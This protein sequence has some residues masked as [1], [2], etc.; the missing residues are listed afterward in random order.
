MCGANKM[1]KIAIYGGSFNPIT[2]GHIAVIKAIEPYVDEIWII[3]VNKHPWNK[4]LI[5]MKHRIKMIELGLNNIIN[6]NFKYTTIKC[7]KELNK[8]DLSSHKRVLILDV[9][10]LKGV[11]QT[12]AKFMEW[13]RKKCQDNP[14]NPFIYFD[15]YNVIGSDNAKSIE[16][17]SDYE[18]LISENKFII[19][20]R[21]KSIMIEP[22]YFHN[23]IMLVNEDCINAPSSTDVRN[24]I[25]ENDIAT[26]EDGT[27]KNILNYIKKERLYIK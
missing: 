9:Q 3:P 8:L 23:S 27:Y 17:W 20:Q 19:V 6:D 25:K 13:L 1:K 18:K 2:N 5:D 11:P 26:K 21:Q 14:F 15:F 7:D 12:T 10:K 22:K 16:D 4:D 24:A